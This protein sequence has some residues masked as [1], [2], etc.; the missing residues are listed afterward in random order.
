MGTCVP[1]GRPRKAGGRAEYGK[2][3]HRQ[4]ELDDRVLAVMRSGAAP[5]S[6][7]A[8]D[9]MADHHAEISRFWTPDRESYTGLG[10]TYVDNPDFKVRYDGKAPGLAE[11]LRDATAVYAALHLT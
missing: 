7:G 8:R 11:F 10:C 4:A 1:P 3:E 2:A 5:D 9:V 6:A